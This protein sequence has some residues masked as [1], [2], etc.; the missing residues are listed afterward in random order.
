[1]R[2]K[3][4]RG[5]TGA[6]VFRLPGVSVGL[7]LIAPAGGPASAVE[8]PFGVGTHAVLEDRFGGAGP[9][10]GGASVDPPKP[11]GVA[12]EEKHSVFRSVTKGEIQAG[13][14]GS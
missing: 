6:I 5:R 1:M 3:F 9:F 10:T 4:N 12:V 11:D 2:G 7:R 13:G 8:T 14:D